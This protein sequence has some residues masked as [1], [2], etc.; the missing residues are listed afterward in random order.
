MQM[1]LFEYKNRFDQ[2]LEMFLLLQNIEANLSSSN[3][4]EL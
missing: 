4:S 1:K 3:F 2:L